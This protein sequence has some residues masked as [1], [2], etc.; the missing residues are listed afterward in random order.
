M[1]QASKTSLKVGD[2]A[3]DFKDVAAVV[4][5]K[6]KNV[7]L[8]DFK[9]KYVVL[10]F[11]PK[12]D[13][14]GDEFSKSLK[15]FEKANSVILGASED[16]EQSHKEFSCKKKYTVSLLSD[17][18]QKLVKNYGATDEGFGRRTT[19]LISPE[20]RIAHIWPLGKDRDMKKH[21]EQVLQTIQQ[22]QKK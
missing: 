11:Y 13:T 8:G 10:Y 21:V 14:P 4:Q 18:S 16:N 2:N 15:D 19:F 7:S 20:G 3:P 1:A 12:D 22:L 5:D 9:G 6:T 17:P